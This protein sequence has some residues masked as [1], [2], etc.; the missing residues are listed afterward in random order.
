MRTKQQPFGCFGLKTSELHKQHFKQHKSD[1]ITTHK[2]DELSVVSHSK[3]QEIE[4]ND[5]LSF[6]AFLDRY[7]SQS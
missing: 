5:T 4:A 2:F 6:D 3:Q 7:F 1:S